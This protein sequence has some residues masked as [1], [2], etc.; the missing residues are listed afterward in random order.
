VQQV[1]A[2]NGPV[3]LHCKTKRWMKHMSHERCDLPENQVDVARDCPIHKLEAWLQRSGL[4]AAAELAA[5][6]KA[7]AAE[8]DDAVAFAAASPFPTPDLLE[9]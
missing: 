3:F 7:V 4:A 9:V 8:V 5:I 1:R 6:E 2:G